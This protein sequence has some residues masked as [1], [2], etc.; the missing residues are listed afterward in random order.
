MNISE[1]S[2]TKRIAVLELEIQKLPF[3]ESQLIN[4]Q[5]EFNINDQ[6]YT[7]LLQKRAEAG[8]TKASNTPDHHFST[9]HG[10]KMQ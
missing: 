1:S 3:T 7:F 8:I 10:R 4:I 9:S 6:I 5:R 2:L